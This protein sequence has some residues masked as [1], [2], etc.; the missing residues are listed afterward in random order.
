MGFSAA[1][2]DEIPPLRT[3]AGAVAH[4]DRTVPYRSGRFKGERPLGLDRRGTRSRIYR[5]DNGSIACRFYSTDCVVFN[6]DGSVEI[7]LG[8]Y[9]ASPSTRSFI[10]RLLPQFSF[11]TYKGK[12]YL[13]MNNGNEQKAT[14]Y[15]IDNKVRMRVHADGTVED[16][17]PE[18]RS[19][20]NRTAMRELTA[21]YKPFV[22]YG[23]DMLTLSKIVQ[24]ENKNTL[25][26]PELNRNVVKW[27]ITKHARQFRDFLG[28]V[29]AAMAAPEQE[30]L[31]AFY[32]LATGLAFVVAPLRWQQPHR[33]CTPAKFR[34]GMLFVLKC[35]HADTLFIREP[36][37]KDSVVGN[38]NDWFITINAM[39]RDSLQERKEHATA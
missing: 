6:S 5:L 39:M 27:N 29:N 16:A 26:M 12:L 1:D 34:H 3:Y 30:K 25:L 9:S 10:T 20:L 21:K 28:A 15:C 14:Y 22:Q 19:A 7:S 35:W 18:Y 4:F 23:V 38:D 8:G 32:K 13:V 37:T 31:D 2:T 36:A 11:R 33:E 17:V 24:P